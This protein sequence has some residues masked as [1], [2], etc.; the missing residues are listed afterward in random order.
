MPTGSILQVVRAT[1]ATLRETTNT[2]FTDADISV[3]I[4]PTS[5]SSDILL[6][7]YANAGNA[8]KTGGGEERS[9]YQLTD[10]SNV[11]LS[12]AESL[13]I[14]LF[15]STGS[16][17]AS[18]FPLAISAFVSPGTTSPVTFKGR[19]KSQNAGNTARLFNN[20]HTGQLYAMEVAG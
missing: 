16:A 19:F 10:S 8:G 4:T 12:G 5:A 6:L 11:A 18:T 14:G 13:I 9:S 7:W 20:I 3:T 17:A 2:S 15:T 1:D